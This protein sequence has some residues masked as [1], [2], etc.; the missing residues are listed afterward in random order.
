[1]Y[2]LTLKFK[3]T[4]KGIIYFDY[5]TCSIKQEKKQQ[6]LYSNTAPRAKMALWSK[7]D[8]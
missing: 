2:Y 7:V 8:Y 6:L 4:F 3:W 5:C 1:M